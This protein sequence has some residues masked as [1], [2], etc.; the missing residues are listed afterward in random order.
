[1]TDVPTAVHGLG[2]GRA[3]S[4]WPGV[5]PA[6]PTSRQFWQN[7]EP[8]RESDRPVHRRGAARG[9]RPRRR[10]STDAATTSRPSGVLEDVDLFDA[11][12]LRLQPARGRGHRPAAAGVPGVRVGGPRERRLRPRHLRRARSA[13][14]RAPA[15]NSYLLD[16][17]YAEHGAR[18]ARS[19]PTRSLLGN[20]KDF[21]PTRVSYKLNLRGPSVTVQTRARPRWSPCTWPARAC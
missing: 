13:S 1:M 14:T 9:R 11:A 15:M 17:V 3:S 5:S 4:G 20:D 10:C 2:Q 8:G 18:P 6:R 21:L 16:N 12:L 7:L 19:A